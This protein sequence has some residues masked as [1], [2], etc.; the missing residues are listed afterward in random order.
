MEDREPKVQEKRYLLTGYGLWNRTPWTQGRSHRCTC[1]FSRLFITDD[2][3]P[4]EKAYKFDVYAQ[5]A[6]HLSIMQ[7]TYKPQ[8]CPPYS[9]LYTPSPPD[10]T[11]VVRSILMNLQYNTK[12]ASTTL[13]LLL[14]N[15]CSRERFALQSTCDYEPLG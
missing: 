3:L 6:Q 13:L 10:H 14:P 4:D 2:I 9:S 15:L 5:K 11:R 7:A 1:L 12:P 8:F